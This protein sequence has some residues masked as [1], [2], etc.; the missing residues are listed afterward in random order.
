M[1]TSL[2]STTRVL[3]SSLANRIMSADEAAA[4]INF[5]TRIG[6]SGFT[7][8]G[9]PKA[10]PM[11][12]AR[13]ISDAN[14]RG[15][16]CQVSIFTGAS[17]GPELD[18]AL[19]MAGGIQLRLPYQ[20]DPET[21]KRINAGE[22]D[23]MDIHL[24]HVAQ[25]VEYGFLGKMDWALVEVT[26]VLEDGRLVPSSSLGN[27]RTWIDQAE[28]VILEV[29]AWQP[30]ELEGMH[31]IY[32]GMQPPPNRQPIPLVHPG[33]RIGTPYLKIAPEKVAA[34]VLTDSPDRNS[35]FKP[36]DDASRR[37]AGHILEFLAW[38][39]KSGRV[40]ASLLPLQ[41]GVGNIA[42]AVLLGL[43]EGK[44]EN[45]TSYTEVIQ[46]GMIEL[47]RSGKLTCASATAFSLSPNMLAKV[48][49]EM[50]SFRQQIVL[51]P[52]EISNH[53]EIIRRL[54]VIG[55]NGMIEADIY[56]NVNSTHVMGSRIQ[57]GIGGSGDF[58][59]NGYLSIFM[60]PSTAQKGS[61]STIVPMVSHVDHT[62]HDVAVI[63][64]EQGLAD[65]RGLSPRQRS[66]LVIQNCAHP[67]YRPLLRDYEERAE[68]LSFGKH[69]PHLL[70]E[71]LGWH[72]RYVRTGRMLAHEE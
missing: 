43:L 36:P 7:G 4:L 28:K 62:E 34:I 44:F 69:T 10:V 22:M 56:G 29:N 1:V 12:L 66:K 6:M 42:N 58:A 65:L 18:G 59:R 35:A 55:M 45:L 54:G 49:A 50:A 17:T 26:A 16:K 15:D 41:S 2:A 40:P 13:R 38:E 39:V 48:N 33:Q 46:D 68:R 51:R 21:R 32:Y 11:A 37:I 60:A 5:G 52:Q 31:D 71:S 63:V 47:L 67:D 72:D 20:S 30:A 70:K 25:Y 57:N 19:A 14:L 3:N 23:Y 24:G 61:I 53:S 9:Y 8:S 64:T 27:N